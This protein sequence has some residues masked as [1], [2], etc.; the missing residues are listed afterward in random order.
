MLGGGIVIYSD[1]ADLVDQALSCL[2]F[3]RNES[4]GKCAPCR[5]GTQKLVELAARIRDGAVSRDALYGAEPTVGHTLTELATRDAR[6]P[7]SAAIGTVAANPIRTLLRHF[8]AEIERAV[9]P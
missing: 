2:E 1:E 6:Q 7:P 9:Q 3:F 8:P 5:V 4:C